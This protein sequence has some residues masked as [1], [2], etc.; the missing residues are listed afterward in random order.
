MAYIV[1]VFCLMKWSSS[2]FSDSAAKPSQN[3]PIIFHE[4]IL[5]LFLVCAPLLHLFGSPMMELIMDYSP[6]VVIEMFLL[7]FLQNILHISD[8]NR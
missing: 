5:P 2:F 7:L 3:S 6:L 4:N 8:T 1:L